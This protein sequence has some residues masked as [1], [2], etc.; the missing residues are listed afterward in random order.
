MAA[1]TALRAASSTSG[2]P[3]IISLAPLTV[4]ELDPAELVSCAASA[5]YDAVGLRLLRVTDTEPQRPTIGVTP[6]IRDVRRRL[7]DSGLR[8][9]DIEVVRLT[10]DTRVRP[11]FTAFLETG[12]YL[13]ASEV[14]VTG[15]DSD[16]TRVADK[17]A[18]LAELA[19]EYGLT[20]NLEPMPWTGVKNLQQG[21][22]IMAACGHANVGLLVDAIHYERALNTPA[23]LS[24]LPAE[25][26]RYAQICD[27][28]AER[29]QTE[30]ELMHQGRNARLFPGDGCI[31]LV[32]M[33]RA[34]PPDVPISVEAPVTWRASPLE[35]A[36]A[37]QRAAR[38]V[39]AIADGENWVQPAR[40]A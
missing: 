15:Y 38:R 36:R 31:D 21:A 27:A 30:A 19:G 8:L 17:L 18:E 4:L 26:I 2:T 1:G 6:L 20:P 14:L 7:D 28:V 33:L 9:L 34:L 29:P 13:S 23:D 3:R 22:A 32:S 40:P 24:S 37:A 25:W 16:H 10:P 12:A 39:V 11:H 35:R 5:G